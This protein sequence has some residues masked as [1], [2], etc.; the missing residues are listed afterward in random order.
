MDLW[1][2]W[3]WNRYYL[4]KNTSLNLQYIDIQSYNSCWQMLFGS[5]GVKWE[6]TLLWGLL[7][8][9]SV[10][11]LVTGW[12]FGLSCLPLVRDHHHHLHLVANTPKLDNYHCS[13][14]PPSP[15]QT[16]CSVDSTYKDRKDSPI[17][18][19]PHSHLQFLSW[20]HKEGCRN[21]PLS[22]AS[23]HLCPPPWSYFLLPGLRLLSV[24]QERPGL[25]NDRDTVSVTSLPWLPVADHR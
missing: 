21:C 22:S 1:S 8:H 6:V 14:R 5:W 13:S 7:G 19:A 24:W 12:W 11:R 17:P 20:S 15:R 23:C 2:C 16:A 10:G 18:P 3:K 4:K 25:D 9:T